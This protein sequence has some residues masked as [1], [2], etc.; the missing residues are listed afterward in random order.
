[1]GTSRKRWISGLASRRQCRESEMEMKARI[2]FVATVVLMFVFL[3]MTVF[4]LVFPEECDTDQPEE[5]D[6]IE[7]STSKSTY[8]SGE[9]VVFILH[10]NGTEDF[11]YDTSLRE[12]LQIFGPGGQ[13][14]LME[15]YWQTQG[16]SGIPPGENLSWSWNQT[17]YL[18]VLEEGEFELAWDYRSWTQVRPGKYTAEI[19]CGYIEKEVEFWIND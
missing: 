18:Y 5:K 7:L 11:V 12:T 16:L 1:M 19:N 8:R 10:N 14:V 17:Y 6:T 9:N 13:I 15:P 3:S 4:L 2:I